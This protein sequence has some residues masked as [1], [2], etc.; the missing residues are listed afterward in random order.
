MIKKVAILSRAYMD[1]ITNII[2]LD[3]FYFVFLKFNQKHDQHGS[4]Q[5]DFS[6][7]LS[8]PTS[9]SFELG[10]NE[11]PAGWIPQIALAQ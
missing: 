11:L 6:L 4:F 3:R 10:G 8:P 2:W 5:R 1:D 7:C 9:W